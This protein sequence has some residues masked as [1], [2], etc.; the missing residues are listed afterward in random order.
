MNALTQKIG[1]L[2]A[3]AWGGIAAVAVW[4]FFLRNQA[5][6]ST[7]AASSGASSGNALNSGYSLG[8]A[9]GVQSAG[10]STASA[11][12][13]SASPVSA[14][15]NFGP[16]PAGSQ[17]VWRATQSGQ[18]RYSQQTGGTWPGGIHPGIP[19][20]DTGNVLGQFGWQWAVVPPGADPNTYAQQLSAA[21]VGGPSRKFHS[22]S[23]SQAPLWSDA[24]PLIGA[25][26]QYAHYVRAVGGPGNYRR[27][28]ERV[29]VQS[30]VH[31]ARIRMLNPTPSALIRVA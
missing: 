27:E 11:A 20:P 18:Q 8:Y 22:G 14:L 3:W 9:Q 24:H 15:W 26:V 28:L 2:P 17:T 5:A 1:P 12:P 30:G 10:V 6:G 13:A 21:G 19:D 16:Q 4:F 29:A 7:G 23:R 31:P 25:P